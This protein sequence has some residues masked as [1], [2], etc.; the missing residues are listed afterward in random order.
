MPAAEL[1]RLQAQINAITTQFE[2]P[3]VFVKS[4]T[5]LLELYGNRDHQIGD[6]VKIHVLMPSYQPPNLVMRQLETLLSALTSQKPDLALEIM[7]SLW[8]KSYYETRLLA[9]AMLGNL[10]ID[11]LQATRERFLKW[12]RPG[13]ESGLIDA[14]ISKGSLQLRQYQIDEW[15]LWTKKWVNHRNPEFVKIGLRSLS[16]ICADPN[17][18]NFPKIFSILESLILKPI[19]PIQKELTYLFRIIIEHVPMETISFFRSIL[20]HKQSNEIKSFFRRCLP[21][22]EKDFQM[23]IK[24]ELQ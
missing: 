20:T 5:S 17:F 24:S 7:D 4:L 23:I 6:A 13:L 22:F 19:F 2:T 15:L 18:S 16:V 3:A 11:K 1:S 14:L 8:Q 9:I 10:P 21:F 12:L